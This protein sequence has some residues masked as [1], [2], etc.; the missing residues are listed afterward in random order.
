MSA[1]GAWRRCLGRR[2]SP[3]EP[4]RSAGRGLAP[5]R[6]AASSARPRAL[7]AGRPCAG[8][9]AAL[10]AIPLLAALLASGPAA[11]QT[12]N[13]DGSYS[14]PLDWALKPSAV[15]DGG[16]FRLLFITEGKHNALHT[17]IAT[18]DG[19]VQTEAAVGHSAITPYASLFKVVGSTPTVDARN[20]VGATGTGVPI[21]WLGGA[22][23]ADDYADF[24][25][26]SWD[27]NAG[28]DRRR[29][30]G[31]ASSTGT[32][33]DWPW[34]GTNDDGTKST[35]PLGSN[36]P[37]RG[38]FGSND[39]IEHHTGSSRIESHAFYA[40]SPVFL[41]DAS[42]ESEISFLRDALSVSKSQSTYQPVMSIIPPAA[43]DI[44]LHFT[45]AGTATEG[46]G[47]LGDFHFSRSPVLGAGQTRDNLHIFIGN[48][49]DT[50]THTIVLTL[51]TSRLPEGVTGGAITVHTVTVTDNN[52]TVVTLAGRGGAE[53]VAE[54][55]AVEL[56]VSLGR[57]LVSGEVI[58]VPLAV[59]GA[60]VTTADWSLALKPGARNP[61][62]ALSGQTTATPQLRFSGARAHRA[63]LVLTPTADAVAEGAETLTVALG[64]DGSGANGF[65]RSTSSTNVGGGADPHPAARSLS[66]RVHDATVAWS[67]RRVEVGEGAGAARLTLALN[68]ART[69]ATTVPLVYGAHTARESRDY[70]RGPASVT[71]AAGATSATVDVPIVDDA[72]VEG[73]E[74][75]SVLIDTDRL[76][77]GVGVAVDRDRLRHIANVVILDNEADPVVTLAPASDAA[78]TEGTPARFTL[79]VSP[80]PGGPLAVAVTVADAPGADFVAEGTRTV[81]IPGGATS[82]TF[83]VATA[84]DETDEPSGTVTAAVAAGEGYGR[85]AGDAPAAVRVRDDDATA[86]VLSVPDAKATEGDAADTASLVLTLARGLRAGERLSVPL[87]FSGA[88]LGTDF[89]LALEGRPRGV[90]LTGATVIFT[91]AA[92]PSASSATVRLAAADDADAAHESVTVRL[93]T[94]TSAGLDG[95]VAPRRTGNGRIALDDDDAGALPAVTVAAGPAVVEGASATFTLTATPAPSAALSVNLSVADDATSDFLAAGTEGARTVTIP[96]AGTATVSVATAPDGTDEADGAVTV[97][98]GAGGGYT[99]GTPASASVTVHDDDGT[100]P[101]LPVLSITGGP[102]ITEGTAARFTVTARPVPAPTKT[103]TVNLRVADAPGADFLAASLEGTNGFWRYAGGAASR[104]FTLATQADRNDEPGGPVTVTL[105]PRAGTQTY[106]VGTPSSASVTVND[107]DDPPGGSPTVRLSAAT[108]AVTEGDAASVTV[109]IAPVRSTTTTLGLTCTHGTTASGDF[110]ACPASV[111]IPAS[112]AAHTFSI[113]TT[114][115]T[116]DEPAETFTVALGTRPAGVALGTPSEAT[117]TV[118]D[119]DETAVV[120]SVSDATAT[121]GDATDTAAIDVAIGRGLGAGE[122]LSVPLAFTGGTAGT[123]FTLALAGAPRGVTLTGTTVTFAGAATASASSARVLLSASSDRDTTDET[124]TV[125][126]GTLAATGL[127]GGVTGRRDGAGRMTLE[128]ASTPVT[129]RW[130]TF[131]GIIAST[132]LPEGATVLYHP[133][134]S[135]RLA[136]HETV[137]FALSLGGDATRGTDYTLACGTVAGVTCRNLASGDASLTFDGARFTSLSASAALRL[138]AVEDGTDE[139][140]ES[141]TLTLGGQTRSFNISDAPDAVTITF[142][143]G[144]SSVREHNS[145]VQPVMRI[146][147]PAGRDIPLHFTL[148]GTATEGRTGNGDYYFQQDPVVLRAGHSTGDIEI[149][150]RGRSSSPPIVL[151]EPDETI[152][153]TL[154]TSRL[155]SW[156]TA[157]AITVNTVTIY[158]SDPTPV[159]LARSGSG[160]VAEG[161]TVTFTVTLGRELLAGEVVGVPLAVS[162]TG[163]APADF[164]LALKAGADFNTGVTLSR[165][166]TATPRL[167]FAGA[168]ARVATLELVPTDDGLDEGGETY[169]IALGPDG[170]GANGFD[171]S[172]LG[173]TVGGGADPHATRHRFSVAVREGPT[174]ARRILVTPG[175]GVTE[176]TAAAFTLTAD[177]VAPASDLS[178]TVT[179]ADAPGADF[180]PGAAEGARTL[181]IPAGQTSVGFTVATTPDTDDEPSGPVTAT[182]TAAAGYAT[183]E[184]GGVAVTDDDRTEVVLSVPDTTA[185]EGDQFNQARIAIT[186]GRGLR[187]GERLSVPLEFTGGALDTDFTLA[188]AHNTPQGVTLTG[189][190]VVFTGG[191]TP[192][193][194]SA[195]VYLRARSDSDTTDETVT[196]SL[197][198]LAATG[199]DGGVTGRLDGDGRITLEDVA[200]TATL[201]VFGV[202]STGLPE[203]AS[204]VIRLA[205]S[206]TL[207][208]DETATFQ[209]TLGGDATRGADYRLAC[210]TLLGVTCSNLATGAPSVTLDGARIRNRHVENPLWLTALEDDTD[211]SAERVTLTLGGQTREFDIVEAPAAVTIAWFVPPDGYLQIREDNGPFEPCMRINPPS[212]RDIPVHFTHDGTATEGSTGA[213]DY[214][215]EDDYWLMGGR[216]SSCLSVLLHQDALDEPTE[217]A[218]FTIDES[219]LPAGV[220]VSDSATATLRLYDA[221]PAVVSLARTG[222]GAV[223][224]GGTVTFTVTLGRTL[225][226]NALLSTG[227]ADEVVGVP[228]AVSGAGVTPGDFSLALKTG[229]DLNTGVTL[230]H[231]DTAT[232]RLRF[233][234]AGARVA[235]LEL[236]PTDDGLDEGGETF[237]VALGPARGANGFDQGALGTNA[238]GGAAPHATRHRFEVAVREGRTSARSVRI[239]PGAGVAE[240]TAARFTLSAAP[241]PASDLAV[242]VALAD[243]PGADFLAAAAEGARTVTV[244]AGQTSVAFTVATGDDTD[245]EPSGAVTATVT[246]AAGY[247][248]GATASVTVTD[249]DPTAVALSGSSAAITEGGYRSTKALTLT[250]GRA[251]VAGERLEVPV[252]VGGTARYSDDYRMYATG[253]RVGSHLVGRPGG[254][255]RFTGGP[256]ASRTATLHVEALADTLDEGV[257]ETVTVRLGRLDAHSGTNLGGGASGSGAVTFAIADDDDPLPVATLTGGAGV[258]EGTPATFTVTVDRAPGEDLVIALDVAD[259][260]ESDFLASSAEGRTTVT[261]AA[262]ATSADL[263]VATVPDD[264]DEPNASIRATLAA[265][266]G[267]ARGDPA[268]ATVTVAD[269]DAT[270]GPTLSIEDATQAESEGLMRFTVRLSSPQ[271]HWV[272]VSATSRESTPVS[273]RE[274]GWEFPRGCDYRTAFVSNT[275]RPGQTE[276]YLYVTIIDDAIDEEPETFELVMTHA[277]GATIA[278]AVAVGTITND[279]PLPAAYLARFGRTVAEQALEGVAGRIGA[280]RTPG[281]QGTLAGRALAFGGPGAPGASG[282]GPAVSDGQA[283]GAPAFGGHSDR[284]GPDRDAAGL[285][286]TQSLTLRDALLGSSF[287]LTGAPDAM[288]GSTAL[289][290]RASLGRFDGVEGTLSLDGEITTGL[291]GADYARDGWLVGLALIQ[292]ESEGGYRDTRQTPRPPSQSCP[293]GAHRAGAEPCDG[294]VRTGEG[295]V[296]ASLTAAIPYASLQVSERLTLWGAAGLGR[297][298]VT[299]ETPTGGRYEADT[300][301]RMAAAGFRGDLLDPPVEGAGPALALTSDALWART[302]SEKTRDLAASRSDVTRLR[303]GLEGRWR[304]ALDGGESG[305]HLTPRLEVGARHD[306]GDAETGFGLELGAG[307]AWRDP[308]RGL[309]L[310]LSGRTLLAHEDGA[311]EDRG[312]SAAFGFDPDPGSER[313]PSFSLRQTFGGQASGGLDALFAPAPLADRAGS[314]PTSRW[315]AEAAWGLPAFGGRFTASP[316]VGLGLSAGARELTLGW[317]WTPAT[318]APDLA[319]GLTATRRERDAA[320]PEHTLGLEATARW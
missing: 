196:V 67:S 272:R 74:W 212:G 308:A 155:P 204:P 35:H 27:A 246:A 176:G 81:T 141:V 34:T 13:D 125:S 311:L 267:Y 73:D 33:S 118:T 245:D 53:A 293:A 177:P 4:S 84:R 66:V 261:I 106:T 239:A 222:S 126:L 109:N 112:A 232:P 248:T 83:D 235:T 173:T 30:S 273:A 309:T 43:V 292:S 151:D 46:R 197:G 234:G 253:A 172:S 188:L 263:T 306:A 93:G 20:H 305:A 286:E 191:T 221:T 170:G 124:V 169:A 149:S 249:D 146:T 154:D 257:G 270:T 260:T 226:A 200:M 190:T 142:I 156:V 36:T 5:R 223:T 79:S 3:P 181:I 264:T 195:S 164:D 312:V 107:D 299:I 102:A 21:Y 14:V 104:T 251:L 198:T 45:L 16:K 189:A 136:A 2:S 243:A 111:T 284:L 134:L 282:T 26:G 101:P 186:L 199:L 103:L 187:A 291:L 91:G 121:E 70:R 44:P 237:T 229:T 231:A 158:D 18:Y 9:A 96:T 145:P 268:V 210:S 228:L 29:A 179:V 148:G 252:V 262:G 178:V 113:Q 316:H 271:S 296:E 254:L 217:T 285:G 114:G 307:L 127:D 213:W 97:T 276:S 147:P 116:A 202:P 99:P 289:W 320:A 244:P 241:A 41:V 160:A 98:V 207:A 209:F 58:D 31:Q 153:L 182:V 318:R 167:R 250:L 166:D 108:Y 203:G 314:A 129:M 278:D 105:R 287:T 297:G 22:K 40:L 216:S 132:G 266:A 133:E 230:L 130:S 80:A 219:R 135:R 88:A 242:T 165:A 61:G 51:D 220:T 150:V 302:A 303:L 214:T 122:R 255:V 208:L 295:K 11:A 185:R 48:S 65:D 32:Q 17:S 120:L 12:A 49:R 310:D 140:A 52:P 123:D 238:D 89:T 7:P 258:T 157:G 152:V 256:G 90:T 24:W 23:V 86:V 15:A 259:A 57:P 225:R 159:T 69:T 168:G 294:A 280:P 138:T 218:V 60:G 144:T 56:T 183:G 117:V 95:G 75:F 319:F 193:A 163:V 315:S 37:T 279:D 92:T 128:D 161:G 139:S 194:A 283:F 175:E 10:A 300:T 54:G 82:K 38:A 184:T 236:V 28:S 1:S 298:D 62:V 119:D 39:P 76:P 6:P 55:T 192:S 313:G 171:R 201:S 281:M 77:S 290:G 25:D 8:L 227:T 224:E 247:A 137:T 265:G 131:P 304:F 277:R 288:G 301:W 87:A 71:I 47:P 59:S 240:G 85:N 115:D 162:G 215:L 274:C 19:Y 72:L 63:T 50:P 68:A 143:R 100:P 206:R 233:A 42:V 180:V 94:P 269:D 110:T 64:P 78:V 275:F 317:R 205:L 211:E 174:R